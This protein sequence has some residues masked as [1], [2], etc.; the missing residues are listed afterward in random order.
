MDLFYQCRLSIT[1]FVPCFIVCLFSLPRRS[2]RIRTCRITADETNPNDGVWGYLYNHFQPIS[3][4]PPSEVTFQPNSFIFMGR[5]GFKYLGDQGQMTPQSWHLYK[6][7]RF[8]N[9]QQ[10]DPALKWPSPYASSFECLRNWTVPKTD[11]LCCYLQCNMCNSR[12]LELR[13]EPTP[14]VVGKR[15][16]SAVGRRSQMS[17]GGAASLCVFFWELEPRIG[18]QPK[19]VVW[20]TMG[21]IAG[22]LPQLSQMP[23]LQYM[24]QCAKFETKHRVTGT[25]WGATAPEAI[26]F[27]VSTWNVLFFDDLCCWPSPLADGSTLSEGDYSSPLTRAKLC[28]IALA[29][30]PVVKDLDFN[31]ADGGQAMQLKAVEVIR[32]CGWP[33]DGGNWSDLPIQ[34][35]K[36]AMARW[37]NIELSG[38]QGVIFQPCLMTPEDGRWCSAWLMLTKFVSGLEPSKT[39]QTSLR[40][41]VS[42]PGKDSG[43][44]Y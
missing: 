41:F 1:V 7:H 38:S 2:C 36:M 34:L 32:K 17:L 31:T 21:E 28:E 6:W 15:E 4:I 35:W 18:F 25:N 5:L 13:I 33:W 9:V 11:P 29:L 30:S 26:F 12:H 24:Y 10:V 23:R 43:T 40:T 14:Q 42:L 8:Q 19:M 20:P 3:T 44:A 37:E 39:P 22:F 27:V 16:A